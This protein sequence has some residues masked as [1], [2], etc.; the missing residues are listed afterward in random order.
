MQILRSQPTVYKGELPW[1]KSVVKSAKQKTVC[2]WG[3]G[4]LSRSFKFLG[5]KN[6][7]FC[8][9]MELGTNFTPV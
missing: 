1:C 5:P 9:D 3:I 8:S 4:V 6:L 7:Y 2:V